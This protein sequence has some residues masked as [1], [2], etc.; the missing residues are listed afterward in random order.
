MNEKLIEKKLREEVRRL[1]GLAIK[2]T[3]PSFTGLPD[4]I[5]LMPNGRIRF[6]EIKTTGETLSDRQDI[7]K[8]QLEAM[9]FSYD[10]LDSKASLT[11]FLNELT[12]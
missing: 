2:W 6:A 1:G 4:R 8:G 9:G 12:R 3:S 10:V 5:V 11:K 7:V